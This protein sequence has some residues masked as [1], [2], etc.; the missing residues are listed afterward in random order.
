MVS[1]DENSGSAG[2]PWRR[3]AQR[4]DRWGFDKRWSLL[5]NNMR[6]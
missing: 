5:I 1:A 2:L 3:L 6:G 4:I